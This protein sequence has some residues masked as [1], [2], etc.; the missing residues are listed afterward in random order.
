M[1]LISEDISPSHSRLTISVTSSAS[2]LTMSRRD[3]SIFLRAFSPQSLRLRLSAAKNPVIAD[4]KSRSII[5]VILTIALLLSAGF[6][7]LSAAVYLNYLT[8]M[9]KNYVLKNA[10][11]NEPP[12]ML[13]THKL[14]G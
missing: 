5:P 6:N 9:N 12:E 13:P 7:K 4:I 10:L 8:L 3:S 14:I 11:G 1:K 2:Y